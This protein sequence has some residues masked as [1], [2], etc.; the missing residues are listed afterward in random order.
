MT[1]D[2]RNQVFHLIAGGVGGTTGAIVTC[3]LEV[4]KTRLQSSNSGFDTKLKIDK[5]HKTLWVQHSHPLLHTI[6]AM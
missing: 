4:V 1:T 2:N 3:P 5:L 6:S